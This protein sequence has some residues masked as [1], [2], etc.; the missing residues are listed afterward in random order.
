MKRIILVFLFV[1]FIYPFAFADIQLNDSSNT[2]L[3]DSELTKN[4]SLIKVIN[5]VTSPV[6]FNIFA[7]NENDKLNIISSF[8]LKG[9]SDEKK[10]KV[11]K[12]I[13]YA[14]F[15]SLDKNNAK[16]DITRKNNLLTIRIFNSDA[17]IGLSQL[18]KNGKAFVFKE[19]DAEDYFVLNNNSTELLNLILSYYDHESFSWVAI[20]NIVNLTPGETRKINTII[21]KQ[22]EDYDYFSIEDLNG[23]DFDFQT[24]VKNDDMFITIVSVVKNNN[25]LQEQD[26]RDIVIADKISFEFKHE[27]KNINNDFAQAKIWVIDT[28]NSFSQTSN[29]LGKMIIGAAT[30]YSYV[31]SKGFMEIQ[32]SDKEDGIIMGRGMDDSISP[33]GFSFKILFSDEKNVSIEFY[34]FT[35]GAGKFKIDNADRD[36]FAELAQSLFASLDR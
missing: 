23:Y 10:V 25:N 15:C 16:I 28:G 9:F 11:N 36:F 12:N 2:I 27:I 26:K 32:Y 13:F 4:I 29:G 30:K 35:R 20:A 33:L 5:Y 19:T 17:D 34:N 24:F 3:I 6:D 22:I 8:S 18:P 1:N 21:D 14:Y 31:E 7:G